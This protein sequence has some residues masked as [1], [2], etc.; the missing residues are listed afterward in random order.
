MLEELVLVAGP[1][2]QPLLL[3]PRRHH[4]RR[5]LLLDLRVYRLSDHHHL[6]RSREKKKAEVGAGATSMWH[7]A[8]GVVLLARVKVRLEQK[9]EGC[10]VIVDYLQHHPQ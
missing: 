1:R 6:C 8:S 2:S 10:S 4:F 7:S 9:D 5:L 3:K